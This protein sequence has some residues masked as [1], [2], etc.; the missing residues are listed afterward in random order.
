MK[1]T[2][3]LA[4]IGKVGVFSADQLQGLIDS[5]ESGEEMSD[6]LSKGLKESVSGLTTREKVFENILSQKYSREVLSPIASHFTGRT[7]AGIDKNTKQA[8]LE[9]FS[10]YLSPDEVSD[11]MKDTS[12]NTSEKIKK[13][14]GLVSPRFHER[15][16]KVSTSDKEEWEKRWKAADT[17]AK[18]LELLAKEVQESSEKKIAEVEAGWINRLRNTKIATEVAKY[19]GKI[20]G[21]PETVA[22]LVQ[23]ELQDNFKIEYN[24]EN[25]Q[26]NTFDQEG[27]ALGLDK[28]VSAALEGQ[29]LIQ[30]NPAGK[31]GKPDPREKQ[32]QGR[33]NVQ[34][35]TYQDAQKEFGKKLK[36]KALEGYIN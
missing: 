20:L 8:F 1:I 27:N 31:N 34:P 33:E 29:G 7:V 10:D 11:V 26:F 15:V 14:T 3:L 23:L 21:K 18:E 19:S 6:E 36:Q 5:I 32:S 28:A 22:K 9:S 16:S 25:S 12:L 24:A 17:K 2:D 30:L 13:L 35:Q 4:E